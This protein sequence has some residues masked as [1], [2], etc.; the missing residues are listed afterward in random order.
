MGRMLSFVVLLLILL[1]Q[2]HDSNEIKLVP[3]YLTIKGIKASAVQGS[4]MLR[5]AFAVALETTLNQ[6]ILVRLYSLHKPVLISLLFSSL[7][8]HALHFITLHNLLLL[9][10]IKSV[11][12]QLR[13]RSLK[14]PSYRIQTAQ[15]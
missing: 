15:G 14:S 6:G 13:Y 8:F 5:N 12:V 9:L 4:A 1:F 3:Y 10:H 2:Q 7:L 11:S